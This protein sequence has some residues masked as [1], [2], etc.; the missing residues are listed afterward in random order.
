MRTGKKLDLKKKILVLASIMVLLSSVSLV[1]HSYA[2]LNDADIVAHIDGEPVTVREYAQALL[3]KRAE[4]YAYFKQAHGV[5]DHPE[6]WT[7][8]YGGEVPLHKIKAEALEDIVHVK[9]QQILAKEKG[10][11]QDISYE[12]FLKELTAENAR[13]HDAL[14]KNQV[15]YGP[16]QYDETGY[17]DIVFDNMRAELKRQLQDEMV[18]TET[19]FESFYRENINQFKQGDSVKIQKISVKYP[20]QAEAKDKAELVIKAI[21]TRINNG[22]AFESQNLLPEIKLEEQSFEPQTAKADA[23][24]WRDLLDAAQRLEAG[25][26]SEII[27]YNGAFYLIK[28]M[29]RTQGATIPLDEAKDFIKLELSEKEYKNSLAKR[30]AD[31]QVVI[32]DKVYQKMDERYVR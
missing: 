21:Q 6:F 15:I 14:K 31:A 20:D 26:I 13:R 25:Q 5:D 12:S 10:L 32:N 29:E 16:K 1:I 24:M 17:F 23:M 2:G 11:V 27:D 19:A 9:V 8:D 22:E 4:V 18:F 3:R 30:I 28:C 7:G